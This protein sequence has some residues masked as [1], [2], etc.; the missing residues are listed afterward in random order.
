MDMTILILGIIVTVVSAIPVVVQLRR[1][2]R[3]LYVLFFA[4]MWE[5]FSYYGMRG[6]LIFYLTQ[7]FLFDDTF[8][9]GKY[10]SYTSLVY[11]MPLV[12]GLLA[13]R[14]LGTRKAVAFG[15]LLLVAGH[16]AMAI[17]GTP[18]VQQLTYQGTTYSFDVQGR[19]DARHVQLKVGDGQYDVGASPEGGMEIK[20]LPAG[21]P[22]PQVLPKGSYTLSVIGR[23][24]F[25]TGIF[26]LALSLIIMGVGFLKP[27]IS[28]IVGQLYTQGDVRR[29]PGFTLYYYGI[30]LGAFWA[31]LLCT[32]LGQTVGWWAGFGL[33]GVGML[34]GYVVFVFGKSWLD[35]KGEPPNPEKL[36]RP[37]LAGL[38]MET[39]IYLLGLLG[40]GVVWFVIQ[41]NDIVDMMLAGGSVL[42]LGYILFYMVTQ[43]TWV[44]SSRLILAMILIVASVVFFTL[45]EQ[46]GSSLNQFAERNTELTF[47]GVTFTAGQTQAFNAGMILLLAPL[48]SFVWAKLAQRNAD[49]NAPAKFGLALMQV[50]AGFYVLAWGTQFADASFKIPLIFLMLCYLLHTTG[51]LCLSPVGL[52]QM[53]KLSPAALIST[54]MATWF[55]ASSWAQRV[56]AFVAQMTAQETVGGQVLDPAA[57]LKTYAHV[58]ELIGFWGAAIGA[59]LLLVSPI[60]G[61]LAMERKRSGAA[62]VPAE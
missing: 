54:V 10:G 48:F 4:E 42:V 34:F 25:Y 11:L 41:D 22:L 40:V 20:G 19:G 32:A 33:A 9:Q 52:S 14:Y 35:G 24:P 36:A 17:E 28:S 58:F 15:A 39:S 57:A 29:D 1:H 55:L 60:L 30:N 27:N 62:E 21:G 50:G 3:G 13:D 37:M 53:T 51:E 8:S 26:Y 47:L 12:G 49:P 61:L 38:S 18:A 16:F 46:G 7:Q 59:G 45:F 56:A 2:P 23:D 6:M 43:A 31:S 5:R 44:E